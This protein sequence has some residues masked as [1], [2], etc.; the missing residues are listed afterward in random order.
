MT[1]TSKNLPPNDESIEPEVQGHG[2]K[3]P[4]LEPDPPEVEGHTYKLHGTEKPDPSEAET[5]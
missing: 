2:G 4:N 5:D 3:F 1:E